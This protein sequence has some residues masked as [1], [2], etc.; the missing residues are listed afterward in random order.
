[1]QKSGA[2]LTSAP[3]SLSC[4]RA[5]VS[6]ACPCIPSRRNSQAA[7]SLKSHPIRRRP[8][9]TLSTC[10]LS[11]GTTAR[12]GRPAVGS[13][14]ASSKHRR[15]PSNVNCLDRSR[16][17]LPPRLRVDGRRSGCRHR[18]QSK[19]VNSKLACDFAALSHRCHLAPGSSLV[20]PTRRESGHYW[21][22]YALFYSVFA[23]LV[24]VFGRSWCEVPD[25]R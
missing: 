19:D 7:R 23:F 12:R 3:S 25:L 1:M 4:A 22:I 6:E 18:K 24:D 15:R 16:F 20:H 8:G 17:P 5:W 21:T 11:T 9:A 10:W 13:S 2:S 14:S